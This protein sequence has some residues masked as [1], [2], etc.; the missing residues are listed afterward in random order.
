MAR[1]KGKPK[2]KQ[3]IQP[4]S[5]WPKG[6]LL[7]AFGLAVLVGVAT[8]FFL[9]QGS[10]EPVAAEYRGGPRLRVDSDSIDL[11]SLPF[12]KFVRAQF[13]LRNV[14]DQPLRISGN[15]RVDAVE[16]C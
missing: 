2:S 9:Q 6:L 16:G 3:A 1:G 5:R 10:P 15:P 12:E 11:G 7:G 13:R 4:R 8:W 14:G